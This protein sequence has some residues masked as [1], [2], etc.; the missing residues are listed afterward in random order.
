MK[1][2]RVI[3]SSNANPTYYHFWN[4]L[5]PV[6]RDKFKIKPTLIWF[7]TEQELIDCGVDITI[8]DFIIVDYH[9]DYHLPW[10]T[11]WGLF[12]ATQ[13]YPDDVCLIIGIDQIPLSGMFIRDMISQYSD[14]S[15]LML[16]ADAYSPNHWSIMG[17]ASPSSY[18]IAK[19]STFKKIY[20]FAE[21]FKEEA[22]KVYNSGIM[23]FWEET[24]GRWGIDETYSSAKL[25]LSSGVNI[26]S[27]NNFSLLCE[28]RIECERHKE[29]HFDE[30]QLRNG[31]YSESH[32]CRPYTNHIEY[33][34]KMLS[35]ITPLQ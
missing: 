14:D 24:E 2:D 32:L 17:S 11:T 20:D 34:N 30:N 6:Y 3:L 13:F 7:G 5:A 27:L 23:G 21:S 18:H 22:T 4:A 19:G 1:I 31:Y 35:C 28:R 12:W 26:V 25:R 16:I 8:G 10:Q 15:Y 9:K 33:I 29:T